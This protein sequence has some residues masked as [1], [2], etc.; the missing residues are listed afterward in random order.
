MVTIDETHK[1]GEIVSDSAAENGR[2]AKQ[3]GQR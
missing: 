3:E 1:I 2:V